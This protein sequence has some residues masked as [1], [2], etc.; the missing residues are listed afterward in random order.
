MRSDD[1][2]Y[3]DS[4]NVYGVFILGRQAVER[5][6]GMNVEGRGRNETVIRRQDGGALASVL[7]AS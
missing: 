4:R 6:P 5:E 2:S 7:L 3:I 1:L